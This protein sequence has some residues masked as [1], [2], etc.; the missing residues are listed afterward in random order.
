MEQREVTDQAGTTWTCVQAFAGVKGENAEKAKEISENN[1]HQVPVVCTPRGG[2]QSVRL[3]LATDWFDNFEDEDLIL[4]IGKA[5][6][7]QQ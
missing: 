2:A 5:Q 3:E 7:E 6:Q 4:A 1:H